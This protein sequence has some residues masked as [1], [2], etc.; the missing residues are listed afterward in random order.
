MSVPLFVLGRRLGFSH[1]APR[2]PREPA[3]VH[4]VHYR[5]LR[6][7]VRRGR[8]ARCVSRGFGEVMAHTE[9]AWRQLC[10]RCVDHVSC[11]RP[12]SNVE[13]VAVAGGRHVGPERS[14]LSCAS[15]GARDFGC[16]VTL[17]AQPERV[18]QAAGTA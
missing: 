13:F 3:S 6:E 5:R 9:P 7:V 10:G 15:L 17:V 8:Q 12:R 1:F 14:R 11:L 18:V 4:G 2:S 16:F